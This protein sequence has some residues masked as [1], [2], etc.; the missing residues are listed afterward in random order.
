MMNKVVLN[1]CYGGFNLS[2]NAYKWLNDNYGLSVKES[3]DLPRHDKRLVECVE[4]L[5]KK[6]NGCCSSLSVMD[7]NGNM[8]RIVEYDGYE[9]LQTPNNVDWIVIE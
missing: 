5:G 1:C 6:V 4:T 7:F 3:D 2:N 8:Y 9:S